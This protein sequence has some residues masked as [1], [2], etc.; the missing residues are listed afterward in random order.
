[1]K[2]KYKTDL[3]ALEYSPDTNPLINITEVPM[4]KKRVRSGLAGKTLVDADTGEVAAAAIIHQIEETDADTFVKV[5]AAGITAAYE[6]SRSG[7]RAF[8]AVLQEYE[9]TPMTGGYIDCLYL[10]WFDG[11]LSGRD[12]GMS[13]YTFKR[14]LR[15]L[16][17]KSFLA[18]RGP[19]VFW[20]NPALFF[21]G[22]RALF[23]KEY[24][25]RGLKVIDGGAKK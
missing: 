1:M 2:P 21:K 8:Q 14:G 5:F 25:R 18:P 9:R 10:A 17:D 11:G 13:E 16:L 15:E 6:L 7:Q 24:R 12:I 20:V 22:D 4:K 3:R 19:N 23:V